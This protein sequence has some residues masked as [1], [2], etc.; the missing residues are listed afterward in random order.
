[1]VQTGVF[2]ASYFAANGIMR[3]TVLT[4]LGVKHF[5]K[6]EKIMVMFIVNWKHQY[7]LVIPP[8]PF[9]GRAWKMT[10]QWR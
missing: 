6:R 10:T 2:L 7:E 8:A 9:A 4:A 3:R 5:R 1:M